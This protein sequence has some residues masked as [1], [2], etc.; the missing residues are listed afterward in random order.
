[1]IRKT[2]GHAPNPRPRIPTYPSQIA[3]PRRADQRA[4]SLPVRPLRDE[5]PEFTVARLLAQA[6]IGAIVII[7]L[8][9]AWIMLPR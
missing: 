2:Q 6:G 9:A 1:M 3:P 7:V 8:W 4:I 5:V